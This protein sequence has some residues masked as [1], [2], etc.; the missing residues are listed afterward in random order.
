MSETGLLPFDRF[1]RTAWQN[2]KTKSDRP[3]ANYLK[4]LSGIANFAASYTNKKDV[5]D[6]VLCFILFNYQ[7]VCSESA[8]ITSKG[9]AITK[10]N[11]LTYPVYNLT[12]VKLVNTEAV[13][14][15]V[16]SA[17]YIFNVF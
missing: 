10:P 15:S 8:N 9:V 3:R 5:V 4:R 2:L 6:K 11:V 1:L 14:E 13:C 12:A 7:T 17:L 16:V